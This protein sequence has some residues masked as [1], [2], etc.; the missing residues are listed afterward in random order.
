MRTFALMSLVVAWVMSPMASLIA[1]D[2]WRTIKPDVVYGHK[3]GMALTYDVITPTENAN[4]AGVLFMVSGGWVSTWF[5][6]EGVVREPKPAGLN[7]WERLVD[8]GYTV[9][10]VRHG[11]SPRFKVPE[12]WSDVELAIRHIHAHAEEFGVDPDRL[13]VC[14]GSAGG[15]LSLMMGTRG[16]DG[17]ASQSDPAQRASS[18]VRCVVAYF[19]PTDLEPYVGPDKPIVKQFPALDFPQSQ[20]ESVSP[21][22]HVT[23]DDAPT[24]LVHGD[25]DELVPLFHSEKIKEAMDEAGVECE[26]IVI[27]GAAHGFAGDDNERALQALADWMDAHLLEAAN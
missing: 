19:P 18:R 25:R 27:E 8:R 14:G 24:L 12:A 7:L 10:M 23:A 4:G 5:A 26:L 9:F 16:D 2:G 20:V 22:R 17:D 11:S 21:L 3:A 1:D 15:H 6:P 13:G